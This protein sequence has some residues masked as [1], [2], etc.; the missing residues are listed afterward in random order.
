MATCNHGRTAPDQTLDNLHESQAG[1]GV[2]R[3]K[4][5]E[6]AY[7]QGFQIGLHQAIAPGGNAE[8][9]HTGRRAPKDMIE[10]LPESQAGPGRHKCAICAYH[11]GFQTGRS[12]AGQLPPMS[13]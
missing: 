3:H 9:K 12:S 13:P 4:C 2:Q 7:D 8:C 10:S 1:P 11:E 6:C 5:T